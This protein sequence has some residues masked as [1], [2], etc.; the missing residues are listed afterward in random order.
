MAFNGAGVFL[1]LFNWVQDKNN[2]IDIDSTR[3][4]QETDGI[5]TGLSN[6]ICRDGQSTVTA[7]IP[8]ATHK[9]TQIKS[10]TVRTDATNLGQLQD[11]TLNWIADSGVADAIAATYAPPITA[12]VDGQHCSV[13]AANANAT[14]TPTFSPNGITAHTITKF[15]G[16]ALGIGDIQTNQEL[17]LR[18]NLAN[19]RWELLDPRAADL[20]A[21]TFVG[22]QTLSGAALN[23]ARATIASA[24]TVNIGAATANYLQVTGTTTIT[25][26]DTIQAGTERT[27]EFASSLMVTHNASSLILPGSASITV[28][29]GD[30]MI[31]RSEGSGNW[32]CIVYQQAASLAPASPLRNRLINGGFAID[33]RVNSATSCSDDTYC[34]DRW[35][36]LTQ[37]AAVNVSQQALQEVGQPF[38]IRLSQAQA[39][40][41]R[42]GVAQI[43]EA[44]NSQDLRSASIALSARIRCSSSQAIRYAILEWTGTA[45][46]VTS[47]VVLSWTSG[48]YTAGNFFL[49]A[50]LT[51]T[52]VGSIT[53]SANTWTAITTLT[54]TCGASVNNL[55]AFFWTEGTAAQNITLDI[56]KV[57][58][59]A[60]T[61]ASAF[62]QIPISMELAACQRYFCK[63]FAQGTAPAN[64]AS[65]VGALVFAQTTAASNSGAYGPF[66]FPVVMRAAPTVTTYNASGGANNQITSI[67]ASQDFTG[68]SQT[69]LGDT[70]F[71]LV[72][73]APSGG[74]QGGQCAVHYSANAE[75]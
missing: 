28:S 45:D 17:D 57:Q 15:G 71:A 36:T 37:T 20:T 23:E 64:I 72:G 53:P 18:Y 52:A 31:L 39:S 10:G 35:Y 75:L 30:T 14:T 66:R 34:L 55:I 29:A 21:N 19:T 43:V 5:A 38:N 9:L 69:G 25:A 7:D 74:T 54:G 1:R 42:M 60:G 67:Q 48:T 61:G 44:A 6:M 12:L 59:E 63:S 2:G 49:A 3:M 33:Q 16:T 47:D 40:A 65:V 27:L 50:N 62:A 8:F 4:D 41:Q 73:I 56:G 68:T 22:T 24:A 51:V 13:R 70:G 46:A 11:S 32:R 58:L 26:F